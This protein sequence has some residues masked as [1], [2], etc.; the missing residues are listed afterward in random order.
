MTTILGG[1]M[2]REKVFVDTSGI[3]AVLNADDHHHKAARPVWQRLIEEEGDLITTNYVMVEL[4]AIAQH[5]LGIEAIRVIQEDMVPLFVMEWIDAPVHH[6]AVTAL[7]TAGRKKL[8]LVD[9]VSF[10]VMRRRGLKHVF[11]VDRH[12]K[13]QGFEVISKV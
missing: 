12:F 8:S 5:R 10:E 13:E 7:L 9:C 11:A 2:K 1:M 4:L 3:L 6:A